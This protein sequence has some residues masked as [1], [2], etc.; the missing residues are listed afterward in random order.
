M[1][2]LSTL[3]AASWIWLT[4]VIFGAQICATEDIV[5]EDD[6]APILRVYCWNCHGSENLAGGLDL[7]NL[8]LLLAGGK[9]GPAIVPGNAHQSLLYQRIV[10]GEMP[11][12]KPIEDNVVYSP[13]RPTA[14]H[15]SLLKRWINGGAHARY[16]DRELN[17][18]EDPPLTAPD[19]AWWAFRTPQRPATPVVR[20]TDR[21]RTPID[22]FLLRKLEKAQ[23]SFSPD[24][25]PGT[26]LRRLYLD[27][28]GLPP[29]A[30]AVTEFETDRDLAA[31][32]RQIERLLASPAFGE[33][34][35]RRW[36]DAA[37]YVDVFGKDND[38]DIINMSSGRWRYRDYVI[39]AF[40][41]GMPY[42]QFVT[43]QLAGDELVDWRNT[44][45]FTEE[46]RR[47]LIA[48]GFLRQAVDSS[49]S[50]ELNTADVRTLVLLDTV[51]I[52]STNLLGLTLHCARCHTHKF[53]PVRQADYYRF[54]AIFAPALNVQNWKR[55]DQRFL[56]DVSRGEKETTD[57]HNVQ[58]DDQVAQLRQRVADLHKPFRDQV[59]EAKL[60]QIPDPIR[61]D[62]QEAVKTEVDQRTAVQKDLAARFGSYAKVEP[63][64]V[65]SAL[66]DATRSQTSALQQQIGKLLANKHSYGEIQALWEFARPPQVYLFRRG[67]YEKP[68]PAVEPAVLAVADRGDTPFRIPT[69]P[70]DAPTSGYRLA[71]AQWLTQ[72]EH[73]L[74]ARVFANRVWQHYFG[75]GIVETPGNFG[76]SGALPSHPELLDWLADEF[77]RSGF[78]IKQL[79][80][81][82]VSSTAYQQSSWSLIPDSR[83]PGPDSIDAENRLLWRM[84]IRRLESEIIRDRI[85]SASGTINRALRGPPI[86]LA[87]QTDGRVEI[88]TTKLKDS[89]QA[90]RRSVYITARRNYHLTQL[91]VFDQPLLSH[92]CMR[93][94]SSAVVLQ[95]LNMLNGKFL[96][97]QAGHL[98]ERLLA[99]CEPADLTGIVQAAYR[100]ALAREPSDS[101]SKLC[102][103]FLEAQ[104]ERHLAQSGMTHDSASRAAMKD[105]CQML[106]NT[107]EFLY[108]H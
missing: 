95:S 75:R 16:T 71:L 35:G 68:G 61:E 27:L 85:L 5:F 12:K 18:E 83:S 76:S 104:L 99:E 10:R 29:T 52:V 88:D 50:K 100:F 42:H 107:N 66:D 41:S 96:F 47:N 108:T 4:T 15:I 49:N 56:W 70:P 17:E 97:E 74:L 72:P 82:I 46:I 67:D 37:G 48:T 60:A 36:L 51:Q 28:T 32:Q 86:P 59:L 98:A 38:A 30:E 81:L 34:W 55:P 26:L 40:N 89:A 21:V 57:R 77:V 44:D 92:N 24:A 91:N 25:D 11:P 8:P 23:L 22:A 62:V 103:S 58:I 79:H 101:D 1:N 7:R 13:V 9:N 69:P 102:V 2:R 90:F 78:D 33:R 19:R 94:D 39:D 105:L 20:A 3:A 80:R 31:S 64:E 73:P 87:P 63:S 54:A 43:E 14:E 84:P 65:N 93:R 45:A 106:M 6:V 53:D